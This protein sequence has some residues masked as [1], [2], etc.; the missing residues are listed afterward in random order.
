MR[1]TRKIGKQ[2]ARQ[3]SGLQYLMSAVAHVH[4]VQTSACMQPSVTCRMHAAAG[5]MCGRRRVVVQAAAH[6]MHV[7]VCITSYARLRRAE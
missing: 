2:K 6:G 7:A 3:R 1:C 5:S 4:A